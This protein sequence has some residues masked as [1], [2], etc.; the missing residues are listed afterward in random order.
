MLTNNLARALRGETPACYAPQKR[1]LYLLAT[2]PQDAIVSWGSFSASGHWAWRWKDWIDRRF[3][4][5]Y[6]VDEISG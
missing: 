4:R 6:V 3:M 5:R 1:S 2:G